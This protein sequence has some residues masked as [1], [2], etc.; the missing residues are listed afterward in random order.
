MY[1]VT[2]VPL[3]LSPI[4]ATVGP[5]AIKGSRAPFDDSSL[6]SREAEVARLLLF[7]L[8]YKDIGERLFISL[9]TVKTH[10]ERIYR[11]T[12]A[13]NKIELAQRLRSG[14][15]AGDDGAGPRAGT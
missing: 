10:V 13:R 12:G 1:L 15:F 4:P 9:S 3:L 11:K 5:A 14:L 2:T 7:G 8:R 6:S